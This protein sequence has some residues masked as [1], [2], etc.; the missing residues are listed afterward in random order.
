MSSVYDELMGQINRM[1]MASK[2]PAQP[3]M[4]PAV[5][6]PQLPSV[7]IPKINIS[8][9]S[10]NVSISKVPGKIE[11]KPISFLSPVRPVSIGGGTNTISIGAPPPNQV[12]PVELPRVNTQHESLFPKSVVNKFTPVK[13]SVQ[14]VQKV[15]DLPGN[16]TESFIK[17]GTALNTA[18]GEIKKPI[19]DFAISEIKALGNV[20]SQATSKLDPAVMFGQKVAKTGFNLV[21]LFR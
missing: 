9:G 5:F 18:I 13:A 17:G 15:L 8:I 3:N 20:L 6:G 14:K 1:S 16:L 19:T 10:P 11:M 4:T 21:G 7:K 12:K 2:P